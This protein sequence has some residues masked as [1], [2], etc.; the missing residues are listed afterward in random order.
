MI[1]KYMRIAIEEANKAKDIDEVPIGCVIVKDDTILAKTHNLRESLN[2]AIAHAEILAIE[3]ACKKLNTWHL[4]GCDI[5][6]TLEPC[7][8][9]AGAIM[10][11]RIKNVYFGANNPKGGSYGSNFNLNKI[12]GLNHYPNV[13]KHILEEECS[14]ILKEY[15]KGKR[16]KLQ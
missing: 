7:P 2:S 4:Y 10:Q 15:F 3:Q 5:Y 14:N 16:K 1:E 8:M 12:R 9:C 13:E 11:S 6:I